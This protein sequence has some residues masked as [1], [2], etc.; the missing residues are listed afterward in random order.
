MSYI[1]KTKDVWDLVTD[2][3]YGKEVECTYV[4]RDE[5]VTD[6]QTYINEKKK[7]FL[8]E[9]RTVYIVKRREAV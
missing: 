9:L 8:P 5:A 7:G 3:G 4:D 6:C 1:R 2:Y